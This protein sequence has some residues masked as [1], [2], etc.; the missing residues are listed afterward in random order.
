[1]GAVLES[2]WVN[3]GLLTVQVELLLILLLLWRLG[4]M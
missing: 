1:M 3:V 4:Q 2:L